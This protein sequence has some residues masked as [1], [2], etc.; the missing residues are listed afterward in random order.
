MK[1]LA[2]VSV[3]IAGA[4]LAGLAA[5]RALAADGANLTVL[6]ARDRVG[7]RVWTL[8]TGLHAQQHGEAGADLI[9]ED[10]HT[11]LA[12]ARELGLRPAR[13]LRGGFAF[14][15]RTARGVRVVEFGR[16]WKNLDKSL[17]QAIRDY[18]LSE[19]RLDGPIARRIAGYSVSRWLAEHKAGRLA[20]ETVLGLRGFFLADPSDLSLLPLVEQAASGGDPGESTFYRLFHGNDGLPTRMADQLGARVRL[21][22]AVVRV[23]QERGRVVLSVEDR[24]G[25]RSEL[26]ADF[27]I[28]AMP[29][30][31]LRE[32][33]FE[34]GMPEQQRTAFERLRY[35]AAT[36]TLL[37]F[38]RPFWR[39][40]GLPRAFGSNLD[41][42]AVWDASEDQTGRH[43]P[44][45]L[46]L[47]AG[48]SASAAT[49]RIVKRFGAKGIVGQLRWL[50]ARG[51]QPIAMRQVVWEDDPWAR[52]GY[53]Y[54]SPDYDPGLRRWLALPFGR[55]LF[56]GEH[57]SNKAQGY[58]EGAV[59]SGLRAAAEIR[60]LVLLQT[61]RQAR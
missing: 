5:A 61:G 28:M 50:G 29:A 21:R 11:I 15:H 36:K 19:E 17:E 22:E 20:R 24:R 30:T 42:G 45:V 38:S 10:Q 6:E 23:R 40:P 27:A 47:L 7:G 55:V 9:E 53:A 31:T 57:T 18:E 56:A 4:G 34:P 3:A 51:E 37:Q 25:S 33:R 32:V 12:L 1:P 2:G 58:M 60:A 35:G 14:A 26:R 48:G 44:G 8:R 39:R 54:F 46:T 49:Q 43:R 41:I 16:T 52:G 59:L 13:I